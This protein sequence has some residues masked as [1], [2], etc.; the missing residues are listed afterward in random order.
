MRDPAD[1]VEK[2]E[3]GSESPWLAPGQTYHFFSFFG[4]L[5]RI[6]FELSFG[7]V[8]PYSRVRDLDSVA[9]NVG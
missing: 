1:S 2:E 7:T 8:H 5:T 6:G 3:E 4:L 9:E